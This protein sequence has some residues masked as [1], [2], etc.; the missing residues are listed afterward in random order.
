MGRNIRQLDIHHEEVMVVTLTGRSGHGINGTTFPGNNHS[1]KVY[2]LREGDKKA[3]AEKCR[4]VGLHFQPIPRKAT[5]TSLER[6]KPPPCLEPFNWQGN[7]VL[8]K[9]GEL[10]VTDVAKAFTR[11]I[12]T[13]DWKTTFY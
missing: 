12:H 2:P 10:C 5:V 4:A 11:E 13:D 1:I 7:Y 9:L 3:K 8:I 6:S